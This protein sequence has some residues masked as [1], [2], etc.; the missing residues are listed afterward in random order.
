MTPGKSFLVGAVSKTLA[1]LVTFPYILAKV[2][3]Q[4]KDTPYTGAID[5]LQKVF[6]REGVIGWY[7]GCQSQVTKAVLAQALLFYFRD[8]FEV[9]TRKILYSA[10]KP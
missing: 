9:W 4:A 3:L 10:K 6:K 5:V 7:K 8:Y 1:T 2:R